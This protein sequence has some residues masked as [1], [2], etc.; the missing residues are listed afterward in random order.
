MVLEGYRGASLKKLEKSGVSVGDLVKVMT[1]RETVEGVLMPR[2]EFADE[3]H[4]V[5]KLKTGYNIGISIGRVKEIKT[6]SKGT[7]PS[8]NVPKRPKLVPSLPKVMILGTGGTIASRIDYRTGGVRP[9]LSSEELYYLVP[10]LSSIAEVETQAL[11]SIYSENM[12]PSRWSELASRVAEAVKAGYD[13]VVITHGTDTLHYTA[14]ALSFALEN[15][16]VPV[17]V[18]GS[19]RSSD[20]PSSDAA[21]N[22][23]GAVKFAARGNASGVFVIM[24]GGLSDDELDVHLGVRVRKDH[25]SRRDAFESVNSDPVG[26]IGQEITLRRGLPPR[27]ASPEGFSCSPSFSDGV[28]IVKLYPGFQPSLIGFLVRQGCRAIILEGTGL[29]HAPTS[30]YDQLRSAI[31]A[32][33][34]VGMT[35]QTIWGS[36]R[37]TVYNTGRDLLRLG[38]VPLGDM[39]SEAAFAK[40]SW[41]LGQGLKPE[42][43]ASM[44]ATDLRGEMAVRRKV[45]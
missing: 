34:F 16:P 29:G 32:G 12:T 39:L 4:I 21:S 23:I 9:A 17:V 35:S 33:V 8:F 41:L 28:S 15:L 36:V 45:K 27:R 24:H 10:E 44:M 6:V 31:G 18:V 30:V 5:I 20:R 2:Y 3:E 43:V 25:S 7:E 40:A 26:R 22:L 38:V 13:G 42:K 19:Q 37:M 14:S 1:D 11:F